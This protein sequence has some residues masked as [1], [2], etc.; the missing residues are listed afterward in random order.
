MIV[1]HDHHES[2]HQYHPELK[3][4]QTQLLLM[5]PCCDDSINSHQTHPPNFPFLHI[6]DKKLSYPTQIWLSEIFQRKPDHSAHFQFLLLKVRESLER[7]SQ[8]LHTHQHH[9]QDQEHQQE[10]KEVGGVFQK[11]SYHC[12]IFGFWKSFWFME[13]FNH[14]K[15]CLKPLTYGLEYYFVKMCNFSTKRIATQL[16]TQQ[17]S[18]DGAYPRPQTFFVVLETLPKARWVA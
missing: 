15:A 18:Y 3:L 10:Q 5:R 12:N 4:S 16:T 2:H 6:L 14:C 11:F 9:H 8:F 1:D 7:L 17:L 13:E